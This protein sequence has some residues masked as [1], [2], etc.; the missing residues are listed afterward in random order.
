MSVHI[1]GRTEIALFLSTPQTN[2]DCAPRLHMQRGQNPHSL[3]RYNRARAIV[4]GAGAG[5]PTIQ[6]PAHHHHLVLQIRIAAGDL[7]NGVI[8]LFVVAGE[9]RMDRHGYRDRHLFPQQP[10][11]PAPVF[12]GEHSGRNRLLMV[13][14]VN[15]LPH[16]LTIVVAEHAPAP[17]TPTGHQQRDRL[18]LGKE[19]RYSLFKLDLLEFVFPK[20]RILRFNVLFL[21]VAVQRISENLRQLVLVIVLQKRRWIRMNLRRFSIENN[22]PR[23]LTLPR[24]EVFLFLQLRYSDNFGSYRSTGRWGPRC[25]LTDKH[26]SIRLDHVDRSADLAPAHPKLAPTLQVRITAAHRGK[27]VACP[28]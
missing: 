4:G 21:H 11:N 27:L 10:A 20:L 16:L 26:S 13:K 23:K 7:R 18:L 22:F 9:F 19:F 17:A 15:F 24:L 8:T 3:H 2:T 6:M 14:A 25:G 5:Y 28:G 1:P 12:A